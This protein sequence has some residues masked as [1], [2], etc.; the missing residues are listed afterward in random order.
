MIR[1]VALCT[2][3]LLLAAA[4]TGCAKLGYYTQ[5][6]GGQLEILSKRQPIETLL[7]DPKT[8]AQL[9][10][11]L[12][13]VLAIRAFASNDLALPDNKSYRTYVD[14]K[15]QYAVW[16]VFAAPELSLTPL[17]WCFIVVGCINYR[18][19]FSP[20]GA[21][22]F[23]DKLRQRGYDVYVGGVTAYSTLGW[24]RDPVLN[25][26]LRNSETD[27][28]GLIFHE[29]AHQRVYVRDDTV[30]NESFAVTV[31][32]EGVKRW[33]AHSGSQ[34][35]FQRYL[36]RKQRHEQF[37]D[38]VM[39]FRRRL[40]ELYATSKPDAEKRALKAALFTELRADYV[41]LKQSWNGYEGYDEWFARDLNNAQL[42]PLGLYHE[43]VPAFRALLAQHHGNLP[44]FY[45]AV[46][47]I[48]MLPKAQRIVRLQ[49][50][51]PAK[52]SRPYSDIR[53]HSRRASW[54]MLE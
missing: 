2:L 22:K 42:V 32:R 28:A 50:L 16:N 1:V 9:R 27:I 47:E 45:R 4:N 26:M 44:A 46:E 7:E 8:D 13:A 54:R 20:A 25:T 53:G 12:A 17:Q 35:Q 51:Q 33:L 39:R 18:G 15:R 49:S 21:D 36:V 10:V 23:A 5:A 29:L 34:E 31:E 6:I 43:Y 40:I 19:Y 37:V 11:Q 3:A 38:L 24:F 14:L 41:R 48:G 30:F 52:V